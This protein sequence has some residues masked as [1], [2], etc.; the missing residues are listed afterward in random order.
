MTISNSI[1]R[2]KLVSDLNSV[3]DLLGT[4]GIRFRNTAEVKRAR[5]VHYTNLVA[6]ISYYWSDAGLLSIKTIHRST[7]IEGDLTEENL[8]RFL[9]IHKLRGTKQ[10][11]HKR[12]HF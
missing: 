11:A 6:E 8:N 2:L 10:F 7:T 5:L 9:I 3:I 4:F 12:S 1:I